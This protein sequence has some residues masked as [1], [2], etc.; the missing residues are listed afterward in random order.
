MA[1][2]APASD[3][4]EIV[5]IVMSDRKPLGFVDLYEDDEFKVALTFY[6]SRSDEYIQIGSWDAPGRYHV[7][8]G[9]SP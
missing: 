1:P 2:S 3:T 5:S 4:G 7:S 8:R 9:D 6:N